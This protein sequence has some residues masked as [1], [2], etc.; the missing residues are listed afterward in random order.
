MTRSLTPSSVRFPLL[1]LAF[2]LSFS[3]SLS[4]SPSLLLS[5]LSPSAACVAYVRSTISRW[6]GRVKKRSNDAPLGARERARANPLCVSLCG[7]SGPKGRFL[8]RAAPPPSL[9][10][11]REQGLALPGKGVAPGAMPDESEKGAQ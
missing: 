10:A 11:A 4:L 2:S 3:L 6:A 9:Y 1:P 8:G 7:A 5:S